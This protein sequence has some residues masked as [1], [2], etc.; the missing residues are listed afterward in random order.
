[1]AR[2][3]G[4]APTAGASVADRVRRWART[5]VREDPTMHP[6]TA[7]GAL[8]TIGRVSQAN[9][10][11]RAFH[12]RHWARGSERARTGNDTRVERQSG[13]RYHSADL[14]VASAAEHELEALTPWL[15]TNSKLNW[16]GLGIIQWRQA[17][18]A[19]HDFLPGR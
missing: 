10:A 16:G 6:R 3:R 2:D 17:A 18:K 12:S 7:N 19:R 1:L 9:D 14:N 15:Q 13:R 4:N 5:A 8:R 11:A